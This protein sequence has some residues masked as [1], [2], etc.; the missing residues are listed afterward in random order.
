MAEDVH[1]KKKSVRRE[2]SGQVVKTLATWSESSSTEFK[3]DTD[4]LVGREK[5]MAFPEVLHAIACKEVLQLLD[6]EVNAIKD[7]M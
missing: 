2:E 3:I 4:W 1:K 6:I 5:S 7:M